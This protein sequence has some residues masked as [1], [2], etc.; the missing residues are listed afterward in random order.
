MP[1]RKTKG[2]RAAALI[3]GVRRAIKRH[4][5]APRPLAYLARKKRRERILK[6]GWDLSDAWAVYCSGDPVEWTAHWFR[7]TQKQVREIQAPN[8]GKAWA[9]GELAELGPG[10]RSRR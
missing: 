9:A 10:L 6:E 8:R 3:E 1:R 7:M 4:D 2:V 5:P